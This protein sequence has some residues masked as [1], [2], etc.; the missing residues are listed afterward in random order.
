MIAAG[1][2]LGLS[3]ASLANAQLPV[4]ET[5]GI[6]HVGI[7]VPDADAAVSFFTEV[8]GAKVI[9]NDRPGPVGQPWKHRFRWHPTSVNTRRIMLQEPDGSQIELFEFAGSQV[10]HAQPHD[11]D[12]AATHIA[13][14]VKNLDASLAVIRQRG[15]TI[16]NE[17][18]TL[19]DGTRWFYF[20][21][22]WGSQIE[23]VSPPS[24]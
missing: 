18:V 12:A 19:S 7:N 9:L 24:R 8:L 16:L 21:T 5:I 15:L 11:D 2:A 13:V 20:L 14:R 3:S 23:L 22:P 10:S 4:I 1:L 6:D 17:P